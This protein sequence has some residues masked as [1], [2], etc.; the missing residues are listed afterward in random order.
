MC[1]VTLNGPWGETQ[2][3]FIRITFQ[4]PSEYPRSLSRSAMPNIDLEKNPEIAL[5]DRAY[6][7]RNLRKIRLHTRPCLEACLRFLLGMPDI[8]GRMYGGGFD[9]DSDSEGEQ[10][11]SRSGIVS[12]LS[13]HADNVPM[14][15]RCQGVFGPN[16]KVINRRERSKSEYGPIGELVCFFP[17]APVII[18]DGRT[19]SPS[20]TSRTGT[21]TGTGSAG[22]I[23]PFAPSAIVSHALRGLSQLAVDK[24]AMST[25]HP[26][27]RDAAGVLR[28]SDHLFARTSMSV[29]SSIYLVFSCTNYEA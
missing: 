11:Q 26:K 5:K 3:V 9:T 20:T 27:A 6:I 28:F 17:A 14:P 2:S 4:F 19:P 29:S 13:N 21:G 10:R 22:R 24:P 16:G 1:T 23:R 25:S 15:R 8:Y 7:L 18:R 12:H